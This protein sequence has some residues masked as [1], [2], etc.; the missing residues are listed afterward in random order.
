MPLRYSDVPPE[1]LYLSRRE[2]MAGAAA[3]AIV[4]CDASTDATA[5]APTGAPPKATATPAQRGRGPPPI[6]VCHAATDATAA[7]PTGAPLKAT[8]N[9][10][11]RVAD[12]LTKVE[13]ATTYNNFYEFGTNK[14]DPA[15][16]AG[17]LKAGPRQ[18]RV[19]GVEARRA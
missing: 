18:L 6:V 12:P 8:T 14:D 5:A 2:L 15:R 19:A 10:A 16:L 13:A 7:A 17:T 4:G 1:R 11:Y 3:L 9:P